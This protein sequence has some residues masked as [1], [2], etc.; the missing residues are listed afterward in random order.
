MDT[1]HQELVEVFYYRLDKQQEREQIIPGMQLFPW[2]SLILG[3]ILFN[4][5]FSIF[6]G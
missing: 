4:N 1:V 5:H 3:A 2:M 6:L